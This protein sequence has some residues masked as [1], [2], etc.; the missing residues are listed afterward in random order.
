MNLSLFTF[1]T[2]NFVHALNLLVASMCCT[3]ITDPY[4]FGYEWTS[5]WSCCRR[6]Q[7]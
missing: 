7:L 5:T 6:K 2:F 4:C 3:S 1:K